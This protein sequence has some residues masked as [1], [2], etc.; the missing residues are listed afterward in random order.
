MP[1]PGAP[2]PPMQYL[3]PDLGEGMAEAEVVQWQV[4]VGDH[5]SRDQI[6]VL[7][8]TDKAE[9]ELPV[10]AAG[11]VTA[12]GA[13]VGDIV[14]VGAPLLDLVPDAG[15]S[16]PGTPVRTSGTSGPATPG[17]P[18]A[19]ARATPPPERA[20]AAPPVRKLARELGVDLAD[21]TG[22]GPAGRVTAADVRSHTATGDRRQPLRGVR[23]AMA[24]NMAEAWR[25]VPHISLFDEID[26]RPL[27][28]AH[29]AARAS[30]G[31]HELTLTAFFVR[32][33][34][35]ALEATPILNASFDADADEVV[36][37]DACHIGIAVA[38]DDGLVVPVVHDAQARDL[39]DLGTEIGRL[40]DLGRSGHL[41]PETIRGATFTV[42]NFGTEGGRFAAPI[43]RP[44]QAAI[45]GFGAVRVRPVVDGDAV[46][47][48][49]ALP[50][51][52]S[53]DH[54]IVDGRDA[55]RFVEAVAALLARPAPLLPEGPRPV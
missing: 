5:V 28:E 3:L 44:P 41:A 6:V 25:A 27:L 46:V 26:A 8:Q 40:T 33:A 1:E 12:L 9:V 36:Y 54:R 14:P 38:S 24:R 18:S 37:H 11:T 15:T 29:S 31:D 19:A 30:V 22:T 13:S 17:S 35:L 34:V 49:P 39:F 23:R 50:I 4:A 20:R 51:S 55:T 48:A 52:L 10:P 16:L 53:A 7:V 47:A 45:L 32:A 21:V 42:T 43:V 2:E